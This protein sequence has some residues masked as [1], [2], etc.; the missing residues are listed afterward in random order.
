MSK[1]LPTCGRVLGGFLILALVGCTGES[2]GRQDPVRPEAAAAP[3]A[4]KVPAGQ[5]VWL[6]VQ[7]P[8]RRVLVQASVCLREGQL[9][10][11]LCR[12]HSK[13]HEAILSAD[14][15][16]RD[17]HKALLAAGG[18]PGSPVQY[19]PAYRPATGTRIKVTL[20][21]EQQGK[22]TTVPAQRWVRN[23]LT[24]K[25]LEH[26]WVF[27]GSRFVLHPEDKDKP[28]L[29]LANSGDVICVSNF[30]SALLDLPVNS[31]KDN[32]ELAFEAHTERIPP[33][34]T[35]VLVILE[36]ISDPKKK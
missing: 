21:Y 7:G 6:E 31:P 17:I 16:A 34:D 12:K 23:A 18:E 1:T 8:R 25:D 2:A 13:E 15:D 35:P 19:Q 30:E 11:L 29:Y 32:E 3:Q 9:E 28:P 5:N 14:V 24:R 26:D 10:L 20:Q 33:L 36:P 22:Q 27:A 4:K